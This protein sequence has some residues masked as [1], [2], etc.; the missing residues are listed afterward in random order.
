MMSVLGPF[1]KTISVP[2]AAL[3]SAGYD[4]HIF[5]VA[6]RQ[7]EFLQ[8]PRPGTIG[9]MQMGMSMSREHAI[10]VEVDLCSPL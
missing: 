8:K 5:L 9:S 3:P 1:L 10:S 4:S 7:V 6:E 2:K